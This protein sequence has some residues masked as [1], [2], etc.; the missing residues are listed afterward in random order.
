MTGAVPLP[1]PAPLLARTVGHVR[2]VVGAAWAGSLWTVG[3]LVAPTLF[4]TL[5][6][7]QAGAIA[8]SVFRVQGMVGIVCAALML[9]LLAL[10]RSMDAK[11]RLSLRLVVVAMLLCAAA[12]LL[13]LQPMMAELK[14]AAQG[15]VLVGELKTRFGMLHG[16][17][18]LVH[19]LQSALAVFLVIKNR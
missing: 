3:Y 11:L 4:K 12:N 7:T 19:L 2:L 6:S 1:K 16:V 13:A 14:A 9:V 18:M 8:G 15:G 5:E 17:S 10:S